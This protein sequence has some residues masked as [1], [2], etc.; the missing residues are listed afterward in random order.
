M[1]L[2]AQNGAIWEL[3]W[4]VRYT[5]GIPFFL[6]DKPFQA[7]STVGKRQFFQI[8]YLCRMRH[9]QIRVPMYHSLSNGP[10][11]GDGNA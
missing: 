1:C 11:I 10:D 2:V 5:G 7:K 4:V 6:Y 8:T 9:Q 3:N